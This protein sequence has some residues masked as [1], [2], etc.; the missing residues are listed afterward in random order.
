VKVL[1]EWL[2]GQ[3]STASKQVLK[4]RAESVLKLLVSTLNSDGDLQA[5]N[6]IS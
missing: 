6:S 2:L 1:V 3:V 4:Q 5:Q